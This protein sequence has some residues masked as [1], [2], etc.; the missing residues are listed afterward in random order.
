MKLL[1]PLALLA[2]AACGDLPPAP[3][4]LPLNRVNAPGV[5]LGPP[6]S[7]HLTGAVW[8][9]DGSRIYVGLLMPADGNGSRRQSLHEITV[10]S[11]ADR[12]LK[13]SIGLESLQRSPDGRLLYFTDGGILW[14]LPSSGGTLE[15]IRAE[16]WY[17]LH[18]TDDDSGLVFGWPKAENVWVVGSRSGTAV[19][20]PQG[21]PLAYS[22]AGD[23]M[24]YCC[25]GAAGS[26]WTT[27][28]VSLLDGANRPSGLAVDSSAY[29]MSTRW[30]A[31]GIQ[32]LLARSHPQDWRL[33]Y[34]IRGATGPETAAFSDTIAGTEQSLAWSPDGS[35]VAFWKSECVSW[36]AY[37]GDCGVHSALY[38]ADLRTGVTTWVAGADADAASGDAGCP[39]FSP[40]GRE[41]VYALW[42]RLYLVRIP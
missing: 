1:L 3:R 41:L 24:L 6:G 16:V 27:V 37:F 38:V 22:P 2:A 12:I 8:S 5:P 29:W 25:S 39:L 20:L 9:A 31:D 13:D 18:V 30:G 28:I 7:S 35:R 26:G 17:I 15:E 23:E 4:I 34:T 11:G 36:N 33:D 21:S 19:A 14:R 32:V 40:D 42:G 10:S